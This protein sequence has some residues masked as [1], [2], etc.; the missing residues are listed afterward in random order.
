LGEQRTLIFH[1]AL[2]CD[3]QARLVEHGHDKI[4]PSGHSGAFFGQVGPAVVALRA[5]ILEGVVLD[6]VADFLGQR[7]LAVS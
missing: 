1:G 2:G 3:D 4:I 7:S 5:Y 6:A